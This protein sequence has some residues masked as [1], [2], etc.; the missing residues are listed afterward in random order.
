MS[1][2]NKYQ[3][4]VDTD[5]DELVASLLLPEKVKLLAGEGWWSTF[6]I[7]RLGIP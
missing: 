7:K 6:P 3:A 4:F 1:P 2:A 5:L